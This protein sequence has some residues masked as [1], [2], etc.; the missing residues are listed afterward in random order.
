MAQLTD[1]HRILIH[2][3]AV[4]KDIG[5]PGREADLKAHPYPGTGVLLQD[6]HEDPGVPVVHPPVA[7]QVVHH[8]G[9]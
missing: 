3:R 5:L 1:G 6:F 4:P 8:P 9:A 2:D 7:I